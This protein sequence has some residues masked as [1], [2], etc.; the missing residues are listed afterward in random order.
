VQLREP[1]D[2]AGAPINLCVRV[3]LHAPGN[4]EQLAIVRFR[5]FVCTLRV[6][7]IGIVNPCEVCRWIVGRLR[8]CLVG[9]SQVVY[10]EEEAACRYGAQGKRRSLIHANILTDKCPEHLSRSE[11]Q[12]RDPILTRYKI[13]YRHP[14]VEKTATIYVSY[15]YLF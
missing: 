3:A 2:R 6:R 13:R 9:M 12:L 5:G 4:T 1:V 15:P 7:P 8:C 11:V 10:G 14:P